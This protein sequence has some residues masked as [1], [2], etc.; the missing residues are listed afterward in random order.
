MVVIFAAIVTVIISTLY[1]AFI[2]TQAAVPSGQ[3]RWKLPP[4]EKDEL[5]LDF[6]F[7]YSEDQLPGVCAFLHAFMDLNSEASSGQF[8]AQDARFGYVRDREGRKVLAMTYSITPVPFDLG[9]NQRMEIYGYYQPQVRAYV[10]GAY[11]TRVKGDKSSWLTVNQP[12]MESLR[13]RLLSWRSQ[14]KANQEQFRQ[15]GEAIFA[16]APEFPVR[17]SS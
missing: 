3:R 15:Q 17:E 6:P 1:P 8:L 14:N 10:L 11:L 12:F 9:V 7:S 2:A 4:P 16:N 13:A 5:H